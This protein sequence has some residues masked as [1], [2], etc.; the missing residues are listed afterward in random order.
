[1]DD[2]LRLPNG[3]ENLVEDETV[4]TQ[5]SRADKAK[6]G[7]CIGIA[8]KWESWMQTWEDTAESRLIKPSETAFRL[9]I[10]AHS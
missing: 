4:E 6:K 7:K 3:M 10:D 5:Q 2:H 8:D 9:V 1:M